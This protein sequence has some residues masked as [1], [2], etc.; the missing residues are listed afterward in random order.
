MAVDGSCLCG[1]ITFEIK[2]PL[3]GVINCHCTQCRKWTGHYVAATAAWK[4]NLEIN[5]SEDN[6]RWYRSSP[7]AQRGFCTN[8]GSSLFWKGSNTDTITILAGTLNGAT[9]L[10]TEAQIHVSDKGDYYSLGHP[11]AQVYAQSGHHVC[12]QADAATE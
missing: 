10:T 1:A 7:D 6:L 2:G 3:R 8:C 9:G 11:Q 12:L 4:H 5:D